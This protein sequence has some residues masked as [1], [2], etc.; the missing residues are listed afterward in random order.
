ME[1]TT[2]HAGCSY[3]SISSQSTH[4]LRLVIFTNVQ[5]CTTVDKVDIFQCRRDLCMLFLTGLTFNSR[6]LH[7]N[8]YNQ[9]DKTDTYK[10]CKKL[11]TWAQPAILY[12]GLALRETNKEIISLA[13]P[14][15]TASIHDHVTK[16]SKD[17]PNQ[18][19]ACKS[20]K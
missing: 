3:L 14:L 18:Y 19:G 6:A 13:D 8:K 4:Q 15:K 1:W 7:I 9:F 16:V 17:N 10:L 11:C 20:K 5:C 2:H 12:G